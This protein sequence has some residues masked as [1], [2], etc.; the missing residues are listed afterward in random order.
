MAVETILELIRT[1]ENE[2]LKAKLCLKLLDNAAI[3]V[4]Y[5]Q[6]SRYGLGIETA[7][8]P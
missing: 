2:T 1:T 7:Y 6:L 3:G 4:P 8:L 5:E